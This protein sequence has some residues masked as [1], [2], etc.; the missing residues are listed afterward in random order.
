LGQIGVE[1]EVDF[2][3]LIAFVVSVEHLLVA[4]QGESVSTE[5]DGDAV[6]RDL[7]QRGDVALGGGEE[8]LLVGG[9][10]VFCNLFWFD[11]AR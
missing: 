8:R 2:A 10:A 7:S 9:E 4:G 11:T 5:T 1:A 6:A 3:Q